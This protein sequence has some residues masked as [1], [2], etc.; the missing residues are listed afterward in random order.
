MPNRFYRQIAAFVFGQNGNV[1]LRNH[2]DR[3]KWLV[4]VLG[5]IPAGSR[6]LDAGAGELRYKR[7]CT[8][9]NYMSQDFAQYD[10]VGD[11][12]GLQTSTWD[13]TKLDII[14]DIVHI[15]APDGS[16]DAVMCIE[17]LEHVPR[18]VD[19]LQELARLLRPRGDLIITAP[20]SSLTHF[21]PYFYQTGYSKYFFEYW[22]R[23][24]GLEILEIQTNGNYFEWLAQEMHRLPS[25][26][27][28]YS[29]RK[30]SWFERVTVRLV[31][32][33]LGDLSRNN[34]SSEQLLAFGLHV[35][36]RKIS[37]VSD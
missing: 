6:I 17:V 36:A 13:Q 12:I 4:K 32:K 23:E 10:G 34:H 37:R 5:G 25:V 27:R 29:N 33:L 19:A 8:H 9:L 1:G 20:F 3:E 21:A 14:S 22:M 28:N 2:A 11:G 35:H 18:P 16:F 15:P 30:L 26:A 24:C 31:L 7:L